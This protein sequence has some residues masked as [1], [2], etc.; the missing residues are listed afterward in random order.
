M[1][2]KLKIILFFLITQIIFGQKSENSDQINLSKFGVISGELKNGFR[3]YIKPLKDGGDKIYTKLIINAGSFQEDEDQYAIA[4]LLEHMAF[5]STENFPDLRNNAAFYSKLNI[6]PQDLRAQTGGNNTHYSIRFPKNVI[7]NLDTILSIYHDI[8]DG[9]VKFEEAAIE[10]ER[11]AILHE[12]IDGVDPADIYPSGKVFF[13]FTGCNDIPKPKELKQKVM[14]SSTKALKRFYQDWYRP[15]LMELVV[16][17]KIDNIEEIE[18]KIKRKFKDIEVSTKPKQNQDCNQ[19]Y[20]E[21]SEHFISLKNPGTTESDPRT[22]WQF[23]YR[24]PSLFFEEFSQQQNEK[25]WDILSEMIRN[26]LINEQQNYNINYL[27]TF[28]P[29]GGLPASKLEISTTDN[30]EEVI[31]KVYNIMAG[32]SEYGFTRAEWKAVLKNRITEE[33]GASAENWMDALENFIIYREALP[34]DNNENEYLKKLEL[35]TINKLMGEISWQPNDIAVIL[36]NG[37]DSP[38]LS[39]DIVHSW[40]TKALKKP[41]KYSPIV[42]PKQLMSPKEV[43]DLKKARIVTRSFGPYNEDIIKL[44]NG[45]TI[46]LKDFIPDSGRY[47]DKIMV[48]GFSPYGASCFGPENTELIL[49]P[50]IIEHSG[51]GSYNKFEIDKLLSHTSLQYNFRNYIKPHETGLYAQ[52]SSEDIETLLQLIYRS[53]TNPR[54][55]QEAF[56]DWK[57]YVERLSRQSSNANNDFNDFLKKTNGIIRIPRGIEFQKLSQKVNYKEA[58]KK[59]RILHSDAKDFTF[60]FTGKFRKKEILPVLVKYLGNLPNTDKKECSKFKEKN[61]PKGN[62]TNFSYKLPYPV[63]NCLFS[64]Q[65]RTKWNPKDYKET[66]NTELLRAAI[67]LKIKDLR[68]DKNFGTY[69]AFGVVNLNYDDNF[70]IIQAN[71]LCNMED[72]DKILKICN[73]YIEELKAGKISDHFLELM[74]ES[75]YLSKWKDNFDG[76]NGDMQEVLYDHYRYEIPFVESEEVKNY[77]HNFDVDLLQKAALKYLEDNSKRVF[78]ACSDAPK[79]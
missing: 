61:L 49:T 27:S 30:S 52:L 76:S 8:A 54:Y 25:L 51:V 1:K 5:N 4:H 21:S 20:L 28:Y 29:E 22:I 9:K 18:R 77:I 66:I 47:Q 63:D 53:F 56:K 17:G 34:G 38:N 11:K 57:K 44:E 33:L 72:Y 41:K 58:F 60:V 55:D 74:K 70:K 42:A 40:I 65:Y 39:R 59:Y 7:G 15:D 46:I 14:N 50:L 37:I 64:I 2:N 73:E 48:Q 6:V 23:F 45:V 71:V 32:I 19:K 12:K 36:P 62:E 69:T 78:T 24:P 75:A 31:Q 3:Y 26:R 79:L 16:V 35:E 67:D 68:Y 13:Y 10:G 43:N